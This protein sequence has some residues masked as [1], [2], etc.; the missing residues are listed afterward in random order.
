MWI[1]HTLACSAHRNVADDS[2]IKVLNHILQQ[3]S[4][5]KNHRKRSLVIFDIDS[6]LI[7]TSYRTSAVFKEFSRHEVHRKTWP[8]LCTQIDLWQEVTE[9][10]DPIDFINTHAGSFVN[11]DSETARYILNFWR[12]RFF[13]EQWLVHDLPFAGGKEFV[14]ECLQTGSDIAYLTGREEKRARRGTQK[15]LATHHFPLIGQSDQ[16]RLVLKENRHT[17]DFDYK[18]YGLSQLKLGYDHVWFIENEVELVLMTMSQHTN[19]EPILFNSVHSGR[20]HLGDA[21][22]LTIESWLR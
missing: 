11:R 1:D 4:Q 10:Y 5:A 9:V 17:P 20:A 12:D 3:I 18:N 13:D 19:V 8:D 6:T 21:K 16:T 15:W 22:P 7:D 2:S 14:H